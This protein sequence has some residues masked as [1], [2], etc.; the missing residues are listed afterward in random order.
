MVVA[1]QYKLT[2]FGVK[3]INGPANIFHDNCGIVVENLSV[4]ELTLMKRHNAINYHVV[5][6]AVAAGILHLGKEDSDTNLADVLTKVIKGERQWNLCWF[7]MWW[8][9]YTW[10]IGNVWFGLEVD[11]SWSDGRSLEWHSWSVPKSLQSQVQCIKWLVLRW[12]SSLCQWCSWLT[13]YYRVDCAFELG[14]VISNSRGLSEITHT[15]RQM[16]IQTEGFGVSSKAFSWPV[17]CCMFSQSY[18][19]YSL[20]IISL[21]L[22]Y[23]NTNPVSITKARW[24]QCDL[25]SFYHFF[26]IGLCSL[27]TVAQVCTD[28]L[29]ETSNPV[30]S[31]ILSL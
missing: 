18:L 13:M 11:F 17:D 26:S 30:H 24:V 25:F 20:H 31:H 8:F 4:P 12:I 29:Q 1:L 14:I 9:M 15:D 6:K 7:L 28:C 10:W 19:V 2:M 27:V 3:I 21:L 5:C 23:I 16:D 22:S